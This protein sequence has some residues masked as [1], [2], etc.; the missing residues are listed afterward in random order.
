MNRYITPGVTL[1]VGMNWR[2][3]LSFSAV[4]ALGLASLQAPAIA[5]RQSFKDQLVGT[6]TTVLCETVQPDG[7]KGPGVIGANQ[8]GQYI[9][10]EDGHFSYQSAAE[11]PKFASNNRMKTTPE[12]E[13][14]V[15]EGSIA[16]FGTYTVNDADKTIALKIE[17]SSFPNLN[18]TVGKRIVTA[19]SADEMKYINPGPIG[20]G[21]IICSYK[22]AK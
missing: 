22:R 9:L 12:E 14:A 15:V 5:Q 11:L 17:R 20:G 3:M 10:T 6:W 18:G 1:V 13:K 8:A 2:N 21:S 19:L 4:T 7:T 16:Y